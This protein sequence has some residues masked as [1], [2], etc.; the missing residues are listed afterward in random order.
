[1]DANQEQ[2]VQNLGGEQENEPIAN[3]QNVQEE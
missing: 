3:I 2:E 1:M